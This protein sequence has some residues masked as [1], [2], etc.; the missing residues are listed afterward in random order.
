MRKFKQKWRHADAVSRSLYRAQEQVWDALART[1]A[2]LP[3]VGTTHLES[4]AATLGR[5]A[6]LLKNYS[7]DLLRKPNGIFTESGE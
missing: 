1:R 4:L 3:E 6:E 5:E 7:G 2:E